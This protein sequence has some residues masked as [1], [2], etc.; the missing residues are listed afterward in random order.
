MDYCFL[1][2]NGLKYKTQYLQEEERKMALVVILVIIFLAKCYSESVDSKSNVSG[3]FVCPK[4]G[5]KMGV[6]RGPLSM[7]GTSDPWHR[8]QC[9]RCGFRW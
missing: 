8:F 9:K 1:D 7:I 3:D 6:E 4:C 2:Q 5:W